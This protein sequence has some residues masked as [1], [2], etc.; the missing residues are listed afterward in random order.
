MLE[1]NEPAFPFEGGDNNGSQPYSGLTVREHFAAVAMQGLIANGR[2]A[3]EDVAGEAVTHAN[4]LI[5]E[6]NRR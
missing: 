4:A 1:G 3:P 5:M 2:M 6:L